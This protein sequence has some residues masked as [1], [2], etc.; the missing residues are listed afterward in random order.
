MTYTITINFDLGT[1]GR[2]SNLQ[3]AWTS[4]PMEYTETDVFDLAQLADCHF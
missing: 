4:I 3:P 1:I 2:T